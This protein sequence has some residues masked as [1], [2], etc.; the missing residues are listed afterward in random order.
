MFVYLKGAK[1]RY[2]LLLLVTPFLFACGDKSSPNNSEPGKP[3]ILPQTQI[4]KN[5]LEKAID[6]K[7]GNKKDWDTFKDEG[8]LNKLNNLYGLNIT[9]LSVTW[10]NQTGNFTGALMQATN[11]NTSPKEVRASLSKVC[12]LEESDWTFRTDYEPTGKAKKDGLTCYYIFSPT[13]VD[14]SITRDKE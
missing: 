14:I 10:D 8:G 2:L 13:T 5:L 6:V 12:D 11:S 1:M 4:E 9:S 3:I 7:K